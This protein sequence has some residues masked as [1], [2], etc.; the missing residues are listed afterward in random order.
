LIAHGLV[1]VAV[2]YL[3][4]SGEVRPR[5]G[6]IWRALFGLNAFAALAGTLDVVFRAN[7][8]YLRTKPEN[9]SLL[10]YFGPWPWHLAVSEIVALVLFTL[11][12]AFPA[13]NGLE[14]ND[15]IQENAL[16]G[17]ER[18][19]LAPR[20]RRDVQYQPIR[21]KELAVSLSADAGKNVFV[22]AGSKAPTR[23]PV[24]CRAC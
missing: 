8:M 24:C 4:G 22:A 23:F 17:S 14:V 3:V 18:D 11:V 13:P 15:Y 10:D 5:P 1:L 9:P 7:Y 20:L 19:E 21:A 6:S 2:L 16:S 12:C